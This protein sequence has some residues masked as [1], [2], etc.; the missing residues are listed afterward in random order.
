MRVPQYY[1]NFKCI[2]DKCRHSC[3]VGWEIDV[4]ERTLARYRALPAEKGNEI[5]QSIAESE[6]G[7]HFRLCDD[8]R[9]PHLDEKGLCR[10]ITALGEGYLC[11]ICREHPRYYG[12]GAD[13]LDG[14]LGLACPEAARIILGQVGLPDFVTVE[15]SPSYTATDPYAAKAH[16]LRDFLYSIIYYSDDA[17]SMRSKF[18]AFA[19]FA[20]DVAFSTVSG[21]AIT[22]KPD[23][24]LC[25]ESIPDG[26][27]SELVS[28][29]CECEALN[30]EW[31]KRLGEAR[32]VNEGE[33]ENGILKNGDEYRALL[34]YFTHRYLRECIEDMSAAGRIMLARCSADL[35]F[36]IA[37]T[38][39]ERDALERAAV[40]FS[41][42]VEYSTDNVDLLIDLLASNI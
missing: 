33:L 35:I 26:Y 28:V 15:G 32:L 30:E 37:C 10:I 16:E 24:D 31:E 39:G 1:F 2:A 40:L 8:E 7:A 21:I 19:A 20:D 17:L 27:V 5:L 41:K 14:G 29:F 3:C 11:D 36:L 38:Y 12:I 6:D 34:F 25:D 42:N 18:S 23:T 13:G 22:A 4:D 9:C